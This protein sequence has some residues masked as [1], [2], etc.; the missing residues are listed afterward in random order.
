MTIGFGRTVRRRI[1]PLPR[2]Q[3]T[4]MIPTIPADRIIYA[5]DKTHPPALRVAD[6][7][8]VCFATCDCFTDQIQHDDDTLDTLD[9]NRIN[10]AT[11]PLFVEGAKAG[12]TLAVHIRAIRINSKGVLATLPGAGVAGACLA[13]SRVDILPIHDDHVELFGRVRLP[14]NPMIGVIGTAPAGEAVSCGI[15]DAHGGNMDSKIITQGTTL[16]LPVHV[17]GALLAIGDLHAAMGDGEVGVSGLEVAGEVEVEVRVIAGQPWPLPALLSD[18]HLHTIASHADLDE[19]AN[20]ATLMMTQIL[21]TY[22]ALDTNRAI[23][24]QS[25]AGDLQISQVVDPNKTCRFALPR[26]VLEQLG[27]ACL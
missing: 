5:M 21:T 26:R 14:L 20:R 22:G 9:W 8:R 7:S 27:I 18:T 2:N 11:G 6:G 17:D 4:A 13:N 23:A 10:P 19:A 15:P 16:F 24:L 12:D 25:L 1:M 3:E